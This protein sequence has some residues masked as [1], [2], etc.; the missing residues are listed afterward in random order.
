MFD[1]V[2]KHKRWIQLSFVLLIVP[3]FAFFGMESYTR[4]MRGGSDIATVD[5]VPITQ[6]E[7]GDAMRQQQ[8]RL[9]EALGAAFDPA[10]LDTP[11]MRQALLDS[12]INQRV[13]SARVF[14]SGLTA[15]ND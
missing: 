14:D 7:F 1:F 4:S 15:S 6:Q 2:T 11:D 10:V 8:E 12:L 3:P 5:G 13:V 9:R